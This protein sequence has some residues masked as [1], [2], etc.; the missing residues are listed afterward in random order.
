MKRGNEGRDCER[1]FAREIYTMMDKI[2]GVKWQEIN[3]EQND[4]ESSVIDDEFSI[5]F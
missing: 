1:I 5:F 3:I 4:I 2:L